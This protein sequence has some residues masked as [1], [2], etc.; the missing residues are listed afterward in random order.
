MIAVEDCILAGKITRKR[1]IGQDV[2]VRF[3]QQW[4]ADAPFP[5]FLL[6][7]FDGT[8]VPFFVSSAEEQS[9]NTFIVA[10]TDV[11]SESR[12][13]ILQKEFYLPL[14]IMDTPPAGILKERGDD[15]TGYLVKDK[16]LG[17]LGRVIQQIDRHMQPLLEVDYQGT[18]LLIPVT[19][20]I[21]LKTDHR[22][23]VIYTRLPDGL[24]DIYLN[25]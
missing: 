23:G 19:D 20:Q 8:L 2:I 17:E 11:P 24:A 5:E 10:F 12:E 7:P 21:I 14:D 9:L 1:G 25:P 13:R 22:R 16:K 3:H 4:P 18:E 15:L 6:L